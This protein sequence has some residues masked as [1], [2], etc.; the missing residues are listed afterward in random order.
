MKVKSIFKYLVIIVL[1]FLMIALRAYITRQL[2]SQFEVIYRI[3]FSILFIGSFINVAIGLILGI[4]YLINEVKK[5]GILK[6]NLPK[7]IIMGVPSM[8]FSFAYLI[9]YCN[10]EFIQ[11][12]LLSYPIINLFDYDSSFIS[13]SQIIFG[14]III[15]SFY[16]YNNFLD[17]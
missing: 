13:V 12:T 16:R 9:G 14:Y 3:N 7:I 5:E 4:E 8:Y 15:T 2:K 11:K 17:K 6:L 1:I 10:N